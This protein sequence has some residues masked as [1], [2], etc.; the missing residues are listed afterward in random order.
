M[1]KYN[2]SDIEPYFLEKLA[3]LKKLLDSG[4]RFETTILALCYIDAL[5]NLLMKGAGTKQRFL[6]LIFSYGIVDNF[7]WDKLNLAEFKKVEIED[8]LKSKICSICYEKIKQYVD[9]NICQYDYSISS[10]CIIKDKYLSEAINDILAF[11]KYKTCRCNIISE[12]L[13]KCLYDST[14]GGILYNKYRCEGVHKGKFD[15]LWDSLSSHFD[16]PFYMDIQD[17]LPDFS[18]PPEFIIRTFEQCLVSLKEMYK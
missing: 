13:L 3:N 7:R 9:Q 10:R 12:V 8:K 2:F 6:N 17:S 15:E 16:G 14:Y 1:R 5:G 11:N 4:N 18:I